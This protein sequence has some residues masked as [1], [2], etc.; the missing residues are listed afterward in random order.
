MCRAK[1]GF[2]LSVR[3]NSWKIRA[4]LVTIAALLAL[5][6]IAPAVGHQNSA[7]HLSASAATDSIAT[8][9]WQQDQYDSI[10]LQISQSRNL[11][12][13]VVKGVIAIESQFNTYAVSEVIN[14]G[15]GYSHDLGLMQVNPVC[16]NVGSANLFDPWTNINYGT[17]GLQQAYERFGDIN[18]A[19]QAY[20]IGII[21]VENGG[22]NWAYSN[23][24]LAYAQQFR[25]QHAALYGASSG[26]PNP[27]PAAP[28]QSQPSTS[29][30]GSGTYTVQS[31]DCL[32]L[33][34][35]RTGV[36]WQTIAANNG[37]SYPYVIYPGQVL[38]L[39][40]SSSTWSYT[41]RPGDTLYLI[42]LRYGVSWEQIAQQNGIS[43]PYLIYVGQTLRI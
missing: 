34:G 42:G 20:N 10:I 19:L 2:F 21:Q 25:N 41:V 15:C 36:S 3:G 28:Q 24:V 30:I 5:S 13:F 43:A 35:Q 18:L 40:S 12:P 8:G 11:D 6:A 32:Y 9:N 7:S 31:G 16:A 27:A 39:T 33:I 1:R 14:A 38:K 29:N 26:A 37:I 23:Q 17:A 22:R 4:T